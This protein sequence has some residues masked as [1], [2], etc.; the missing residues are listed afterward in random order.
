MSLFAKHIIGN[1][2]VYPGHPCTIALCILRKYPRVDDAFTKTADGWSTALSDS[3]IPGAGGC[4]SQG[5]TLIGMVRR[6]STPDAAV[7]WGLDAWIRRCESGDHP[8]ALTAGIA[9]G[10]RVA[11]ILREELR[12]VVKVAM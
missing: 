12:R 6:G 7:H 8:R 11:P 2:P 5:L 9:E 1:W 4:V 3:D 10:E